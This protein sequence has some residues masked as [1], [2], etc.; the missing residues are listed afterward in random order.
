MNCLCRKPLIALLLGGYILTVT[1]SGAFHTRLMHNCC[2]AP[3]SASQSCSESTCC[4]GHDHQVLGRLLPTS[5]SP[6]FDAGIVASDLHCPVCSFL[7]QKPVPVEVYSIEQSAELGQSL[8]RV[9]A[10]PPSDDIPTTVY[11]RGPPRIA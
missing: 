9:R 4:E 2:T 5:K 11:G 10:I 8:V 7:S 6:A 3:E 1:V